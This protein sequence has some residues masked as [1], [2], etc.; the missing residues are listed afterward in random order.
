MNH[1]GAKTAFPS[2]PCTIKVHFVWRQ[3]NKPLCG[4][5]PHSRLRAIKD[6]R[7]RKASQSP[8]DTFQL[9]ESVIVGNTLPA[10]VPASPKR[11]SMKGVTQYI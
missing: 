8:Y 10:E 9:D 4:L 11:R 5:H 6:A 3:S 7:N 2:P 1:D